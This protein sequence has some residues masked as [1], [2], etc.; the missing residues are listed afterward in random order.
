MKTKHGC[1]AVRG[2]GVLAVLLASL[3]LRVPDARSQTAE[4]SFFGVTFGMK[5]PEIEKKWLPLSGGA[6]TVASTAVKQIRPAFDHEGRLYEFT[7]SVDLPFPDDPPPL[8]NI[9]FQELLNEKG[10]KNAGLSVSLASSRDG[11][12]V[13]IQHERLRA[14]YVRHLQDKIA[15]L[16][17]P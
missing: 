7:F 8:V 1:R 11:S 5:K 10:K 4:F 17:Q 9:A 13:T 14:G 16:L 2:I 3:A 15:A 12:L 6:Y